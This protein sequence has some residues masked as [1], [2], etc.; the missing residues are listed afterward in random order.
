ML[1]IILKLNH[2]YM[3]TRIQKACISSHLYHVY[4]E[5]I[6]SKYVIIIYVNYLY[7]N[8]ISLIETYNVK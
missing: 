6:F 5:F 3:K 8:T 2:Q 1:L 4:C 7:E